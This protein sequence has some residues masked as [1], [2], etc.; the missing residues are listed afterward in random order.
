MRYKNVIPGRLIS[1]SF[2]FMQ[3]IPKLSGFCC[4]SGKI[5]YLFRQLKRRTNRCNIV[6]FPSI[7]LV[8][9]VSLAYTFSKKGRY[10]Y[11]LG[12]DHKYESC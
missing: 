8:N 1:A 12:P 10:L 7:T 5:V 11:A 4:F 3:H 6:K 2:L 9:N